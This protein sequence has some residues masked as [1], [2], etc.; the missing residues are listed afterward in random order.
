M[1]EVARK[2]EVQEAI[3]AGEKALRSLRTAQEKLNS[4]RSCGFK[5]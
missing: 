4:A 5:D 3:A 2:R 1:T